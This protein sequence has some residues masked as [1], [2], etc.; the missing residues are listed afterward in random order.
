MLA[1]AMRAPV[2]RRSPICYSIGN[3]WARPISLLTIVADEKAGGNCP[4]SVSRGSS[5]LVDRPRPRR[6][7]VVETLA[8]QLELREVARRQPLLD[9][10]QDDGGKTTLLGEREDEIAAA[11]ELPANPRQRIP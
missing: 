10:A 4:H 8:Q 6:R 9:G 2:P 3:C 5:P 7:D 1:T 11:V